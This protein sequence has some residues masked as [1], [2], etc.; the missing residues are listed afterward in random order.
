MHKGNPVLSHG[1]GAI[2]QLLTSEKLVS[3]FFL[4]QLQ[5]V[6]LLDHQLATAVNYYLPDRYPSTVVE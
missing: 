4:P 3:A 2:S 6:Q 5:L 1:L